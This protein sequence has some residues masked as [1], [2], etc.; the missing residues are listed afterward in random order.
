MYVY[1]LIKRNR[2]EIEGN[3]RNTKAVSCSGSF[4]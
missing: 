2:Y 3:K 4:A 1:G